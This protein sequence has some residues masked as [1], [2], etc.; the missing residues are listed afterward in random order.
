VLPK[1]SS[2]SGSRWSGINLCPEAADSDSAPPNARGSVCSKRVPNRG[3]LRSSCLPCQHVAAFP[4]PTHRPVRDP[5][6]C[7]LPRSFALRLHSGQTRSGV[8]FAHVHLSVP[9]IG[10]YG[11]PGGRPG[12]FS[13]GACPVCLKL[14]PS[15]GELPSAEPRSPT[16]PAPLALPAEFLT[17]GSGFSYG[18]VRNRS[19][20]V[21]QQTCWPGVWESKFLSAPVARYTMSHG[22][23]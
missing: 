14:A 9:P 10:P 8:R 21:A 18:S 11:P 4:G 12:A 17:R 19:L 2:S 3:G 5:Q 1:S 13:C 23:M 6:H 22:A 20:H 15:G 7:V 16:W